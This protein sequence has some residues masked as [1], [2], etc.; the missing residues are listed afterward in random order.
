MEDSST[1]Q[2]VGLNRELQRFFTATGR[3]KVWPPSKERDKLLILNHLIDLFEVGKTYDAK[4][5]LTLLQTSLLLED[6]SAIRSALNEYHF[7]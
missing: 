1:Q 5:V 4:E 7:L 3:L 6:A 2:P